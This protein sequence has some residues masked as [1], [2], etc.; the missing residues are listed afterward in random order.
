MN[1]LKREQAKASDVPSCSYAPIAQVLS[2]IPQL[3][4][5]Q[6][7][8]KFDTAYFLAIE[9][10]S[11]TKFLQLCEL[12]AHHG[13]CLGNAYT[14]DIACRTIT[15]YIA[16]SQHQQI[17]EGISQAKFFSL[18]INGSTDKGNVDDE[19]FMVV[20]CDTNGEDE[21]VHTRKMYFHVSRPSTVTAAGLFEELN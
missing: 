2:V 20:W 12:E 11:F 10:L 8:H 18:L 9:K 7:K 6:L 13:V 1:L 16:E 15:H 17:K 19:L 5:E 3:E 14:N 21:L 4:K